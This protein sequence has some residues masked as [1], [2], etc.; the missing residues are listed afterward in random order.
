LP[1]EKNISASGPIKNHFYVKPGSPLADTNV[2]KCMDASNKD[3]EKCP[4][5]GIDLGN[6]RKQLL[7]QNLLW[8]QEG[9]FKYRQIPFAYIPERPTPLALYCRCRARERIVKHLLPKRD[10][11]LSTPKM[12]VEYKPTVLKY[13]DEM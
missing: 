7:K 9:A 2:A 4:C 13:I 5:C 11:T 10:R 1:Q 6:I 3:H 8:L 12:A